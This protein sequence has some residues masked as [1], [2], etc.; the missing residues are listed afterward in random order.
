ME[1]DHGQIQQEINFK[2]FM[3]ITERMGEEYLD[4]A[5]EMSIEETFLMTWDMDLDKCCGR[6]EIGTED[7]GN[8]VINKEKV[9]CTKL[10]I[11][12]I[13]EYLKV[14]LWSIRISIKDQLNSNYKQLKKD[15]QYQLN[16]KHK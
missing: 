16:S 12:L 1:K 6:M 10:V 15:L 3:K 8:M 14:I 5:V 4:G 11:L 13:K 7:T 9:K 2:A